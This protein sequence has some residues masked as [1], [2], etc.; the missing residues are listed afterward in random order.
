VDAAGADAVIP[1]ITRAKALVFVVFFLGMLTGALID[2][3]YKTR[4]SANDNSAQRRSEREVN[5]VYDLLDLTAEQ[6]HQ[7][8]SIMDAARPD[9]EK[10]FEENRKLLEPNQRKYFELQEE[11][12]NK[13]RAILSEEQKKKYNEYYEQRRRE[14][15]GTPMPRRQD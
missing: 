15:R 12:R 3:V 6:R 2:N 5:Q 13:I 8:K 11:T 9:F 7:F 4:I 10:L 14:R 1:S